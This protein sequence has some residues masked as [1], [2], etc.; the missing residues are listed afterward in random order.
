LRPRDLGV[1]PQIE[2]HRLHI[3]PRTVQLHNGQEKPR[4]ISAQQA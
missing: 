2:A 3:N 4:R 1:E